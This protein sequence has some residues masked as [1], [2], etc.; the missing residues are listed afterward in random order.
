[1]MNHDDDLDRALFALPLEPLPT[2][3]RASIIAAVSAVP[4]PMFSR[5]DVLGIGAILALATWLCLSVMAGSDTV[6]LAF[7]LAGA[8]FA[9][10]VSSPTTL[11]WMALG[12]SITVWFSLVSFPSRKAVRGGSRG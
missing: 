2:G 4:A 8:A 5:W 1:M 10:F 12:A 7:S 6:V 9:K 3:L 11:L